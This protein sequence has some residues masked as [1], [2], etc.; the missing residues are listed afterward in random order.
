M[1]TQLSAEVRAPECLL[2]R[3]PAGQ[4]PNRARSRRKRARSNHRQLTELSFDNFGVNPLPVKVSKHTLQQE[5]FAKPFIMPTDQK[6]LYFISGNWPVFDG[7]VIFILFM[8][9]TNLYVESE[10]IKHCQTI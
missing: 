4:N 5:N 10:S 2:K 3:A 1:I 7:I 6:H 8:K 9:I